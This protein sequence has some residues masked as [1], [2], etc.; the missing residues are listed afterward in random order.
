ME[1]GKLFKSSEHSKVEQNRCCY[2][3]SSIHQT[4]DEVK[5]FFF[6]FFNFPL[7]KC[8]VR[9]LV[10]PGIPLVHKTPNLAET[11]FSTKERHGPVRRA[12]LLSSTSPLAAATLTASFETAINAFIPRGGLVKVSLGGNIRRRISL[13]PP[14]F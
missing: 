14:Y 4:H 11:H 3:P 13:S 8:S 2:S 1:A 10:S 9:L 12:E 6:L 5:F 7:Q